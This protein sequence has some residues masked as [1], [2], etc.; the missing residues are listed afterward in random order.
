MKLK[1]KVAIVTGAASGMGQAIALRYAQEGA[2]VVVAD[3]NQK[4]LQDTASSIRAANG[5]AIAV[6]CDVAQEE[7]IRQMIETAVN[8]Y[9]GLDILVNN[10]GIMDNMEPPADITDQQWQRIFAVNT[11]SVMR[12]TRAAMPIFLAK[13]SGVIINVASIG[14]L[15][16]KLAGAT[17]TA[18]K[19]AV[20]GFTKSTAFMYAT[21]GI[22]CN[23]IAP[24]AVETNIGQSMTDINEFGVSRTSLSLSSNPG[25]GKSEY[26]AGIALFLATEDSRF[27]NGAVIY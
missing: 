13:G 26:M 4:S 24:G 5:A 14:G 7:D 20:I 21:R 18:S 9:Q 10:A 23:A 25:A 17:Y 15:Y 22:R 6:K 11:T 19:H 8:E 3:I 1:D 16:G 12:A 27:V 2:K